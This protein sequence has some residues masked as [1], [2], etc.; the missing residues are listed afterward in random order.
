ML[1]GRDIED[2]LGRIL[3]EY[4]DHPFFSKPNESFDD[5]R[6][7]DVPNGRTRNLVPLGVR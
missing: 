4:S 3:Q 5:H 7:L 1:K 2:G 6:R